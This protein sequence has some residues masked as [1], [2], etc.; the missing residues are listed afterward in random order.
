MR[1]IRRRFVFSGVFLLALALIIAGSFL[2]FGKNIRSAGATSEFG[3]LITVHDLGESRSFLSEAN[4]VEDALLGAGYSLDDRDAVEPARNE[5]LVASEY[6][7]NI[8]RARPV[9]IV[10]G[11]S[12][13]RV[14]TPYQTIERIA[15]D[16]DLE[17]HPE[18]R[19]ELTQSDDLLSAGAGLQLSI[20]RATEFAFELYGKETVA[21]TQATAVG[22]M[23][24]DKGIK[25]GDDDRVSPDAST[26]IESG[27]RVRVWREGV[28]TITVEEDVDFEVEKIQDVDRPIGFRE[29]RT[30]GVK[31]ERTVT[32]QV[33]IE[34]GQEVS[35]KEIASVTTKP[36]SKQVEVV[37][38]KSS[39]GLTKSKGVNI[40]VDSN[41]VSHRETYYDLRMST[42][43]GNCSGGGYY[44][45]REDGAKVDKDGYVIVAAH[46]G[47]YPRCSIVETSIGLGKVYDTG[48]FATVHP[49][50]FDLATDWTI[51]DG[52]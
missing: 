16:A 52:I 36:S 37:G 14:M 26:A 46:L 4:T 40:Y 43:M 2:F 20:D 35:R 19:A 3:K 39:G 44:S 38:V 30:P 1:I 12:R 45:V 48:G 6:K 49:Y 27:M 29:V 11:L 47:N 5:T 42:V 50:G 21:R 32:Y 23:L 18:D 31:G 13:K 7:V 17:I 33:T 41:G 15:S 24:K 10:D 9:T 25:L 22:D 8:Y 51:A 34:N 28:Q